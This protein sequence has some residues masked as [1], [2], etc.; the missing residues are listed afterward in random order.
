MKNCEYFNS[1]AVLS[2][3]IGLSA[4]DTPVKCE[5]KWIYC[6]FPKSFK[7]GTEM[8]PNTVLTAVGSQIKT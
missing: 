1:L 7:D 2:K 6:P 8:V 4:K 5:G 3:R